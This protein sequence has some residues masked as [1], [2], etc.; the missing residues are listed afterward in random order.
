MLFRGQDVGVKS[1]EYAEFCGWGYTEFCVFLQESVTEVN[2]SQE[3]VK[4][5]LLG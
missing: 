2:E 5:S 3:L 4:R 1:R